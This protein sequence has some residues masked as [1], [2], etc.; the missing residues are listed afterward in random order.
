[1]T[2]AIVRDLFKRS[3]AR[4][5]LLCWRTNWYLRRSLWRIG[6]YLVR[7]QSLFVPVAAVIAG[8]IVDFVVAAQLT[9]T[10]VGNFLVGT[11][12]LI[13]GFLTVAFALSVSLQQ[14]VANLY[15]PQDLAEYSYGARER[16]TFALLVLAVFACL[17]L[18]LYSLSLQTFAAPSLRTS[19]MAVGFGALGIALSLV[20][21]QLRHGSAQLRPTAAIAFLRGTAERQLKRLD[22]EA[23]RL[24]EGLRLQRS[25]EPAEARAWAYRQLADTVG[26]L[27]VLHLSRLQ[28]MALRLSDRGDSVAAGH[29]LEAW[30]V[31]L[32]T[33]LDYRKD[34]SLVIP[35]DI[36]PTVPESDS[37]WILNRAL[38]QL[39]DLGA[40]FL[41][42]SQVQN[43]RAVV[44][45]YEGFAVT[46]IGVRFLNRQGENPIVEQLGWYLK[47]YVEA[48]AKHG[49]V[50]VP[51]AAI[52][53]FTT[54]W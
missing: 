29:A 53:V 40:R 38:E 26:K 47:S 9:P 48:A 15:S 17:A 34:S 42:N 12:T 33:Y 39:N 46:A 8:L 4:L 6:R 30:S 54:G 45:V 20:E 22:R 1:M 27:V 50:E 16:G 32:R 14:S 41:R 5:K 35:S 23:R 28:E 44:R 49:D 51:F 21:G 31:V 3:R 52:D 13:G 37:Q 11:A 10:L 43:A 19:C 7:G 18:G 25:V 36:D 2:L 24:S